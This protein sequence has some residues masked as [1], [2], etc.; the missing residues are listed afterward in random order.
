MEEQKWKGKNA[1]SGRDAR[2]P[3]G[4]MYSTLYADGRKWANGIECFYICALLASRK[5]IYYSVDRALLRAALKSIGVPPGTLPV[6]HQFHDGT[7]VC[8]RRDDCV[9]GRRM[10]PSII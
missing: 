8:M 10:Y 3:I 6:F 9:H 4:M 1:A 7:P 5:H 2:P